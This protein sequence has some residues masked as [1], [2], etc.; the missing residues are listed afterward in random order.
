MLRKQSKAAGYM[1]PK[2]LQLLTIS[3]FLELPP[4][5]L[6]KDHHESKSFPTAQT[7]FFPHFLSLFLFSL[8]S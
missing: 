6:D 2:P 3:P 8:E 4:P 7:H 1:A 5:L